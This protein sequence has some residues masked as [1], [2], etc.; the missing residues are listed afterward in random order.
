MIFFSFQLE[1]QIRLELYC[2]CFTYWTR[3]IME[4]LLECRL[5]EL[6]LIY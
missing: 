2:F 6:E 3:K 1:D 4:K 5:D